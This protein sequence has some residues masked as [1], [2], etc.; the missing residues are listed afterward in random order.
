MA[1]GVVVRWWESPG[2]TL[3]IGP[4]ANVH[5][6]YSRQYRRC[7]KPSCA[8][9]RADS[10]GHGPYW[11]AYWR[12]DG[13]LRSRYLGKLLPAG[14]TP[15]E[16]TPETAPFALAVRTLGGFL[17]LRDGKRIDPARWRRKSVA[18]LFTCLLSTHGHRLHREQVIDALWPGA[19]ADW[20]SRELHRAI[21]ALRALLS[22]PD[23][24]A[25]VLR[26]D[27]DILALEPGGEDWLDADVFERQALLALRGED[28]A[29]CREAL[30][31]YGGSYLPDDPY[32]DWALPRREE[33]RARYLEVVLHLAHLSGSAGDLGET[34]QCLRLALQ[35][36]SCQE[37]AA[38]TLMG[39]LAAGG[40][41]IEALR[42]YQAL[43]AALDADLGLQP[44]NEIELLRGRLLAL[45]GESSVLRAASPAEPAAARGNLPAAIDSYVGREWEQGEIMDL[46]GN[47][48]LVTLTGPG[49]CGK[50]RLALEA[51]TKLGAL[52]PDG[53]WLA[54]LAALR[55]GALVLETIV[56][57]LG[58]LAAPRDMTPMPL[59]ETLCATLRSRRVLL[60]L[61][62]CE[63]LVA[64]CAEV[65]TVLLRS[66]PHLRIFATSR[67]ALSIAGE[68]VWYVPPLAAPPL[69]HRDLATLANYDSVRL[70]VDRARAASPRFTLAEANAA[71]VLQVCHRL[72]G[73]P[74][75]IELAAARLGTL[76]VHS[77]AARL[78]DSIVLLT[79]GSRTALPR[80]QTLRA[81]IDW[82]YSLLAEDARCLLRRLSV[83]AGGWTIKAAAAVCAGMTDQ[84]GPLHARVADLHDELSA[85][86]LI[87]GVDHGE[88]RRFAMLETMRQFAR[89]QLATAGESETIAD[90]HRAWFLDELARAGT[91]LRTPSQALWLDRLEA[92]IDNLRVSFAAGAIRPCDRLTMLSHAEPL[93]HFCL[94]RG[95]IADGRRWLSAALSGDTTASPAR[96][97]ALNAAGT[98]ASEQGDYGQA[99]ALYVEGLANYHALGDMRGEAR[100][101]TNQGNVAKYQGEP[102][103]ARA[104][105]Q[106]AC[107]RARE[108][109]DPGL[110]A[111]AL[112]NL[113]TLAIELGEIG[114][115]HELLE[116]SLALKRQSA[117]TAGIIQVLVNLGE[118]ARARDD[119]DHAT[120]RYEEAL[121]LALA[122]G[123][124]PHIALVRYNLGL[125]AMTRGHHVRATAELR[126]SLGME[127]EM[128][129]ARQI[130]A[131]LEGFASIA[132]GLGQ[133]G[134]AGLLFGAAEK[135]REQIGAPL[136]AAD[137]PRHTRE[138]ASVRA[139]LSDKESAG[140]W[141]RG[142]ALTLDDAVAEALQVDISG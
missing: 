38:A 123:D 43:A 85:R 8:H 55:D 124:R 29:R 16:S 80:Q 118:V 106:A 129:N 54:E 130:A 34:E 2:G 99:M 109:G 1:P 83:F 59:V 138:T 24:S 139:A 108:Y 42:V 37:G 48:R 95:H 68:T 82:S 36:D 107:D 140:I 71:A 30:A 126:E 41:R 17:V 142:R 28:R 65:V 100:V 27:R 18:D 72:D 137:S 50:T 46:I 77:I 33:L 135:L 4:P 39:I 64:S 103:R 87:R 76:T 92:D 120:E 89:E 125:I 132:A 5:V 114:W 60:I 79:G 53:I 19:D 94:V 6:T 93:A 23:R 119:P 63:H 116:E 14:A 15:V 45:D 91:A 134:R 141:R 74:L 102:E 66:C 121:Q 67:E 20:A 51:A 127:Q 3:S 111:T 7:R 90:R 113:G 49:G 101:F 62:N 44:S 133:V 52:F 105:Y 56:A 35:H 47:V 96:G 84:P 70:F 136:P 117:S 81:T 10:P 58:G 110:L 13:R 131:A 128:G 88:A 78:D 40:R 61:D 122:L 97:G 115:A 86:S 112:N 25:G 9:C 26:F 98:L 104:L 12:E 75:A 31:I 57:A 22:A 11:F 32:S 21:H 73:L 69:G